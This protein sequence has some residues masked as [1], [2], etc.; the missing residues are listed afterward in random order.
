V[1]KTRSIFIDGKW[2]PSESGETFG[3][4]N[5]A[6][7]AS[8]AEVPLESRSDVQRAIDAPAK[9]PTGAVVGEDPTG[10]S[11]AVW[12]LADLVEQNV[13]EIT[14]LSAAP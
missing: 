6:T 10:R 11:Q 7:E 2:V 5:P 13:D 14:S 3:V 8:I 9:P 4:I 12:K 1:A